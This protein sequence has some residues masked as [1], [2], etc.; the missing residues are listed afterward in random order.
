MNHFPGCWYEVFSL[1]QPGTLRIAGGPVIPTPYEKLH[2][3]HIL[4]P[5]K[6]TSFKDVMSMKKGVI[7]M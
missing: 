1:L 3:L 5:I 4:T 2:V 6:Y 7:F